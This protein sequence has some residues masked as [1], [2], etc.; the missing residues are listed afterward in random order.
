MDETKAREILNAWIIGED[1]S[2]T[3][4]PDWQTADSCYLQWFPNSK[5]IS[6][7]G[8]LTVERLEAIIWWMKNKGVD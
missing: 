6:I 4:R 1:N 7:D 2:I 8:E 5:E 3:Q